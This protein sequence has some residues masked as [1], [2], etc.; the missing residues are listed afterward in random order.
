LALPMPDT[1]VWALAGP[2]K[3]KIEANTKC[4]MPST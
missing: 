4:F 3:I 2:A 1:V